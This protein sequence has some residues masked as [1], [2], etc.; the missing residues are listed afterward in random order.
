MAAMTRESFCVLHSLSL[1]KVKAL[2]WVVLVLALAVGCGNG[3]ADEQPGLLVVDD[4]GFRMVVQSGSPALE[5]RGEL[6]GFDAP[7]LNNRGELLFAAEIDDPRADMYEAAVMISD[8]RGQ[9][10]QIVRTGDRLPDGERFG[11]VMQADQLAFNHAGQA[12]LWLTTDADWNARGAIYR[13]EAD[14]SIVAVYNAAAQDTTDV[15]RP[16]INGRGQIVFE[17]FSLDANGRTLDMRV[18]RVDPDRKRQRLFGM[19]DATPDGEYRLGG[20]NQLGSTLN[21]AGWVSFLAAPNP[22]EP[23]GSP[24]HAYYRSDGSG[25]VELARRGEATG[26]P[27]ERF[28]SLHASHYSTL[29]GHHRTVFDARIRMTGEPGSQG[30]LFMH[31]DTGLIALARQGGAAPGGGQFQSVGGTSV[32]INPHGEAVFRA[33][34]ADGRAGIFLAASDGTLRSIA[35]SGQTLPDGN[36]LGRSLARA[37]INEQGQVAF[38]ANTESG[39]SGVFIGAADTEPRVVVLEGQQLGDA[40]IMVVDFLGNEPGRSGFNDQGQVAFKARLRDAN[41]EYEAIFIAH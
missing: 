18:Y 1:R 7:R 11:W 28:E 27:G 8:A 19:G 36:T 21:E 23:G 33:T 2:V 29:D 17:T 14:G 26:R 9:L 35:L 41:H 31:T 39:Q 20:S 22:V 3:N 13:I 34:L 10:R 12:A 24:T 25:L 16:L 30:V 4:Q 40:E 32:S 37:V 38:F 5:G 15:G 6:V